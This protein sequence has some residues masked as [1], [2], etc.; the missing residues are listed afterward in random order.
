MHPFKGRHVQRDIIL[1][2]VSWYCKYCISYRELQEKLAERGDNV[3][4]STIYRWLQR[5]AT[6]IEKRLRCYWRNHSDLCP[7]HMLETYVQV[8]GRWAD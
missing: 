1:W 4:H 6:E 5:Y 7:W 3:D 2:A 8:I